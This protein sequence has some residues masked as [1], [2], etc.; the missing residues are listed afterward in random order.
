MKKL[1][2]TAVMGAAMSLPYIA[3]AATDGTQGATSTGTLDVSLLIRNTDAHDVQIS[4]LQDLSLS[5]IDEGDFEFL[6]TEVPEIICLFAGNGN[7]VNV[8]ISSD[9]EFDGKAHMVNGA[10][11][12]AYA[13]S[14]LNPATRE[15]ATLTGGLLPTSTSSDC[16]DD[17]TGRTSLV[18]EYTTPEALVIDS[19]ALFT[20]TLTITISPT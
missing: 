11:S 7:P 9:N 10:L 14:L 3:H 6:A 16:I 8:E 15:S 1:L 2:L 12:I 19:D 4:G 5:P 17:R 20:D 18:I 13:P